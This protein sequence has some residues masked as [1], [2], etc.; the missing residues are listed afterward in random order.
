MLEFG[1]PFTFMSVDEDS[2]DGEGYRLQVPYIDGQEVTELF[3]NWGVWDVEQS[4]GEWI[5]VPGPKE[6][7]H[8]LGTVI[9]GLAQRNFV[10]LGLWEASIG[11]P[12]AEPGSWEHYTAFAPPWMKV[13][14]QLRP[15][16]F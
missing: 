11:D 13:W 15:D 8:H 5:K 9:T 14:T 12:T 2:W 10:I 4:P 1:N 3:P 16:V 6:F 7:R